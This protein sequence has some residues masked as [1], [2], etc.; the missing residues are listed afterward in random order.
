MPKFFAGM[1]VE[2]EQFNP[3]N[4]HFDLT[5]D[6][7]TYDENGFLHSYED[8]PSSL[9]ISTY[10]DKYFTWHSHGIQYR[11]D[12]K[13]VNIRVSPFLYDTFDAE[14]KRHS[15]ND[16]PSRMSMENGVMWMEWYEHGKLHRENDKPALLTLGKEGFMECTYYKNNEEH[17]DNGKPAFFSKYNKSWKIEGIKHNSLGPQQTNEK[18]KYSSFSKFWTLY[19]VPIQQETFDIIKKLEMEKTVPLWVAFL[20]T[21]EV[22]G[23]DEFNLF[24]TEAG[25]WDESFPITWIFKSWGLTDENYK[26]KIKEKCDHERRPNTN[27]WTLE[28]LLKITEYEKDNQS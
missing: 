26:N 4:L 3:E 7:A 20:Y 13:P 16:M 23:N 27:A 2:A 14:R 10:G 25:T 1:P 24:L 12:N 9:T 5:K 28:K 17:R 11:D 8:K 15:F 22:I 21:F 18:Q 6:Y 19:D